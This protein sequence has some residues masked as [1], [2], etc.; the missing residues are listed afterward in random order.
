M[1]KR[2]MVIGAFWVQ[3]MAGRGACSSSDSM[4]DTRLIAVSKMVGPKGELY[5]TYLSTPDSTIELVSL[6]DLSADSVE[7]VLA[8]AS[9]IVLTGGEDVHPSHYGQANRVDLCGDIDEARDQLEFRMLSYAEEHDLPLLGICRGQQMMTVAGKGSLIADIPSQVPQALSH[10]NEGEGP[11]AEHE[12]QIVPGTLLHEI[13]GV[14]QGRVNS[15][16][17]QCAEQV[18]P[19]LRTNAQAPDGIIEGVE[20][21]EGPFWLG[22]QWHPER[23]PYSDPLAGKIVERFIGEVK[24]VSR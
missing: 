22:V 13:T 20:R 12:V 16:H 2:L 24:Q 19:P 10:R 4:S 7:K 11:A 3:L 6:Y 8:R 23:M 18:V 1:M 17:H 9:G 5:R 21:P 15:Y 14:S